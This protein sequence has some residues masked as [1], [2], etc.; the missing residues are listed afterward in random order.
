VKI[1]ITG[2]GGFVGRHLMRHLLHHT[3]HHVVCH[4]RIPD[5]A[6]RLGPFASR[7]T[8]VA[9]DLA[10]G[11]AEEVPACDVI[12]HAAAR[13]VDPRLGISDYM[14]DNF[15]ATQNL[16]RWACD[17]HAQRII[18]LSSVSVH[19]APQLAVLD[20]S[21]P[22]VNPDAYGL[23]KLCGEHL[24]REQA[25][26]LPAVA[27][28]LPG[29]VGKGA[30]AVWLQRLIATICA[31]EPARLTNPEAP[32]NN[33]VH[34]EDLCAF[35]AALAERPHAGFVALPL[36]AGEPMAIKDI[37]QALIK[38]LASS[39]A[40]EIQPARSGAFRI[41]PTLAVREFGYSAPTMRSILDR[42]IAEARAA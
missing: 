35:I 17:R 18:Y 40:I 38:G 36:A 21:T 41:D 26:A 8:I 15:F 10:S 42:L 24:L 39:S 4:Y 16:A 19:G 5:S 6:E 25:E 13:I 34:V 27:L 11:V 30:Q 2:A 1:L 20:H 29:V 7:I 37:A 33:V 31:G 23:S 3:S 32:F 14:R 28:R 22:I 9:G 12:V